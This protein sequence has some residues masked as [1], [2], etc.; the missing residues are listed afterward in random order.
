MA[1]SSRPGSQAR[2]IRPRGREPERDEVVEFAGFGD[3][4]K[5][6]GQIVGVALIAVALS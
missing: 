4:R 1:I 6:H 3:V 5:A 2:S